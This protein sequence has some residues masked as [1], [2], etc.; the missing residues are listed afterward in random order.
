M[1]LWCPPPPPPDVFLAQLWSNFF[2][3]GN[4]HK[5]LKICWCCGSQRDLSQLQ[6]PWCCYHDDL[7]FY[8][9]LWHTT[10]HKICT[11]IVF[12][13]SKSWSVRY[14]TSCINK[15]AGRADFP[16]SGRAGGVVLSISTD[17][18]E[19]WFTTE[20]RK[21]GECISDLLSLQGD[22]QYVHI[23]TGLCPHACVYLVFL[24]QMRNFRIAAIHKPC[25]KE[26]CLYLC[27]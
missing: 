9:K 12:V 4:S 21:R 19:G 18:P 26:L 20:V 7:P 3:K 16:F 17:D 23:Q 1:V 5:C 27:W 11:K 6:P 15:H 24:L 25:V 8:S 10:F 2:K 22:M 13:V 14:L